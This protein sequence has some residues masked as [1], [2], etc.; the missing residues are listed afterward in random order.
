MVPVADQG[1]RDKIAKVEPYGVDH[2]PD[3]ERHGKASSQLFIWFAA[4]MNFPIMLLGFYAVSFGLSFSAAVW[5]IAVGSFAGSV[6]MG[7]LCR[8][9]IRL[10][11]P[12]Q[13]QARGPLGFF[14]NFLPVAYINVFAGI[15]WAAVTVIL[16]GK[17]LHEL[18]S[19]I[20]FW[21][22]AFVLVALQLVVALFGYNMIHYLQRILAWVLFAGFGLI[23]VVAIA[24]G[25]HLI[26][27]A[28]PKASYYIGAGGGWITFMGYFL[29]FLIA[30]FPFASDYSRYLP[31]TPSVSRRAGV[32]TWAGNFISLTWLGIAG[33]L[34]GSSAANGADPITAL[35]DLTGPWAVPALLAVLL[36][37][38]SQNFLNVYGGAISI[39]TLRIPVSRRIAVI[40][41][42]VPAFLISL[43]ASP[44]FEDKFKTFLFLGAYLIG[45]FA[46]VLLLDYY[47]GDRK[48][49]TRLGELFDENRILGWGFVAWLGGTLASMP[50]WELSIYTGPF[51]KSHPGWGDESYFVGA[52]VAVVLYLL[53]YRLKPLWVRRPRSAA[54]PAASATTP[55]AGPVSAAEKPV[56]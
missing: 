10:G 56:G 22:A 8:M 2:I 53:T 13:I 51:A 14:G 36:S 43:W 9:G 44:G 54:G 26:F 33:A 55:V 45:P 42:C 17:A 37:S 34:L 16:G 31:D 39:Q 12:Q 18:V 49:K 40:M 4:G 7:I 6:V 19:G 5:A 32:Y 23:T 3:V 46:V 50:F 1:Y 38:F 20:P 21:L 28:N 11:V 41:I 24:R 52:A 35:R 48:D 30:W 25:H 47:L 29:S 27:A 15:G